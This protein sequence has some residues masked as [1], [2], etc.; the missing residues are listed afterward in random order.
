[1]LELENRRIV[2]IG[3]GGHSTGGERIHAAM[4]LFTPCTA[5]G[6]L[7]EA[8][9]EA[10]KNATSGDV[11]LLAPAYSSWDQFQNH[12]HRGE[13]IC[14]A[15]ESIGWGVRGGTPNIDGKTVTAQP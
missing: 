2:V 1:M 9:A 11:V 12:Q 8:L 14:Q 6:S 4:S 15:V 5:A 10:A 3:L 13:V 7:L